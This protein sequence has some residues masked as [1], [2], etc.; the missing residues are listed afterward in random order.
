[1]P[2][3]RYSPSCTIE[4][5]ANLTSFA[6]KEY[7]IED[8][9]SSLVGTFSLANPAT[10]DTYRLEKIS[11]VDDGAWHDCVASVSAGTPQLPWQL[12]GCRYSL[13]RKA[14]KIGFQVGW[15]CDDRDPSHP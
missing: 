13:D 6:L 3:T 12:S 4:S 8:A 1:M 15:F 14:R 11:V 9:S 7:Q 2:H 5:F 10:G